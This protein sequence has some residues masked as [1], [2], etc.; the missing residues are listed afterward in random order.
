[1]KKFNLIVGID[2]SKDT[3]DIQWRRTDSPAPTHHAFANSAKGI[4]ELFDLLISL[5]PTTTGILICG[6]YTGTYMDKFSV[7]VQSLECTFWPVHPMVIKSYRLDLQRIKNDKVD[8]GK[9]LEF[10][11]NHQHK[12]IHFTHKD[13]HTSQLKDLFRLKKQL[14]RVQTQFKNFKHAQSQQAFCNIMASSVY[15]QMISLCKQ[16]IDKCEKE[17]KA[18]VKQLPQVYNMYKILL[19]IPGIGPGTAVHLLAVSES[20]QKIKSYK[21]FACFI[22]IAPFEYASGSSIRKRPKVSKKAYKSIKADI[23]QGAMSV[24]RKGLLFYEYYHKMKALNK[25][26]LWIMNS[27]SNKIAKLAFDLIE[28]NQLFNK[29]LYLT[30]KVSLK[31]NL[32]MS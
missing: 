25:P 20:F 26:H 28:K 4:Q 16:Y 24:I 5:E 27:I 17:I 22:G 31:N 11:F 32:H 6:E 14:T 21:A 13:W 2:F 30:N 8:A 1:M 10:A 19:S 15:D 29:D 12:A 23:H 9:I 7:A 18:L 3:L